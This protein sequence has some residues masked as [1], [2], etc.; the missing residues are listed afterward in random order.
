L[1]FHFSA[2]IEASFLKAEGPMPPVAAKTKGESKLS[3]SPKFFHHK[4]II[5]L[6]YEPNSTLAIVNEN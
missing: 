3:P 5:S 4:L 1:I 6:V 2:S